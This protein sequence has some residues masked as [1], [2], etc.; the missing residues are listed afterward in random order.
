MTGKDDDVKSIVEQII[1]DMLLNLKT[2]EE[3]D[4]PVINKLNDLASNSNLNST[5]KVTEAIK[6]LE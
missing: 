6:T 5:K 3:F 1:D 2:R 4:D